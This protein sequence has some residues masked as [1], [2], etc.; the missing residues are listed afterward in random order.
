MGSRKTHLRPG[1]VWKATLFKSAFS[2]TSLWSEQP[3]KSQLD[4]E[5][6]LSLAFPLPP[7]CGQAG[8]QL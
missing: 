2:I 8:K 3:V 1:A 4:F 5:D 7:S 6:S